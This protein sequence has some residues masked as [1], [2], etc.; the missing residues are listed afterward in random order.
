MWLNT[1]IS[2]SFSNFWKYV[3]NLAEVIKK[4]PGVLSYFVNWEK[5]DLNDI[6]ELGSENFKFYVWETRAQ[7]KN[8]FYSED[9]YIW[10]IVNIIELLKKGWTLD[11]EVW[12]DVSKIMN[13][14]SED[15]NDMTTEEQIE[16]IR[17][18]I[19]KKF[20]KYEKKIN[21]IDTSKRHPEL[22]SWLE[23][24]WLDWLEDNL[25]EVELWDNFNSLD[26][27]KLLYQG[28][29]E[30]EKF[31]NKIKWTRPEKVKENGWE[32]SKYYS[33]VEI[34]FRLSD[35]INWIN[36]HGWERRQEK[37][38]III[39][40]IINWNYNYIDSLKKIHDFIKSKQE[41][42]IFNSLHFNRKIF[43][44]EWEEIKKVKGKK[45][46]NLI[47][48]VSL[49]VWFILT[50]VSDIK[51]QKVYNISDRQKPLVLDTLHWVSLTE[52][53]W[54][55]WSVEY[56]N[57]EESFERIQYLWKKL[58]NLFIK[59]YWEWDFEWEELQLFFVSK[60]IELKECAFNEINYWDE[61]YLRLID[62][63]L[64]NPINKS[65]LLSFWFNVDNNYWKY[66]KYKE[67][68]SNTYNSDFIFEVDESEVE[69]I[70][71]YIN[72]EWNT[73]E[74]ALYKKDW[75][76]YIVS[77]GYYKIKYNFE[78]AKNVSFDFLW[79]P[80]NYFVFDLCW[81][82]YSLWY[83]LYN[84]KDKITKLL[85]DKV[86]TWD[87]KIDEIK[88]WTLDEK[89]VFLYKNFSSKLDLKKILN[90][91]INLPNEL[92][93]EIVK[94]K[95]NLFFTKIWTCI[96]DKKSDIEST[97]YVYEYKNIQ[98]FILDIWWDKFWE[99][100]KLY[101]WEYR[102]KEWKEFSERLLKL[103]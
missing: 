15:K 93:R 25:G 61:M 77:R 64:D 5:K 27:A 9:F 2:D 59:K 79:T 70:W 45:I 68:F 75:I 24:D 89:I 62:E 71:E 1:R 95:S 55:I 46:I 32:K 30:D 78:D 74:I 22:F 47:W 100:L 56:N 98:Y 63:I 36:I 94:N 16:F 103:L 35:Y 80:F 50:W 99:S 101:L 69:K 41:I 53:Y 4:T 67:N 11:I 48:M 83:D 26:I 37:Y 13:W 66:S 33:L 81:I 65:K 49:S 102:I 44:K 12:A 40:A 72:K 18:I 14:K 60:M 86:N 17:D 52:H 3:L 85:I 28:C 57:D 10:A 84:S 58:S 91:T 76:K 42:K 31:F 82:W 51:Q 34:A 97:V 7:E 21:I 90:D 87:T 6:P 96:L 92:T 20:K 73:S 23:K 38:D 54:S 8:Q 19:R 43:E 29:K 39:I 88:K